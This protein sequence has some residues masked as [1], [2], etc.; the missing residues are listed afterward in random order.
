MKNHNITKSLITE[1][2]KSS[3]N[4]HHQL[5]MEDEMYFSSCTGVFQGESLSPFLFS[6]YVNEV[7]NYLANDNNVGV[8]LEEIIITSLLF[9]DDMVILSNTR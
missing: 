5:D 4:D 1:R 6:M 9:A 3:I 7:D 8:K 2:I